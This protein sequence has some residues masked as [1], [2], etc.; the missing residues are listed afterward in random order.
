MLPYG[1]SIPLRREQTIGNGKY[2]GKYK[3]LF[4][5]LL[6]YIIYDCWSQRDLALAFNK[7]SI[8]SQ[9]HMKYCST[10]EDLL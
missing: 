6:T 9:Y 10:D 4:F 3:R 2:A 1:N 7:T 5:F 8:I